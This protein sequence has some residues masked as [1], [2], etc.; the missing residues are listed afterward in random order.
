[1]NIRLKLT[2]NGNIMEFMGIKLNAKGERVANR[3]K[4]IAILLV[5]IAL[6]LIVAFS[7]TIDK[8]V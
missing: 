7:P 2:R 8:F 6:I 1:M 3:V 4:S 5:G